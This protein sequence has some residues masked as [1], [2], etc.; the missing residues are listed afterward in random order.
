[1]IETAD[2]ERDS[3]AHA[4]LAWITYEGEQK[5]SSWL[6]YIKPTLTGDEPSDV[7][8]Y[9]SEHPSFPH[10]STIDQFFDEAQWESYRRLAEHVG[11][12]VIGGF[13]SSADGPD[14]LW[15]SR[16]SASM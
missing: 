16:L 13:A 6:L 7:V 14:T 4:A 3:V 2:P 15:L 1:M 11:D 9:H 5:P 8:R 12:Q 10:E